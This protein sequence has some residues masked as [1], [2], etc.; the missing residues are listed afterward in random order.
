MSS[1]DEGW[2]NGGFFV[3]EPIIFK[4]LKDDKTILERYPLEKFLSLKIGCF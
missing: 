2:I 4:Y 1:L 3:M